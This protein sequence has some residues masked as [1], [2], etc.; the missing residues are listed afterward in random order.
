MGQWRSTCTTVEA[1]WGSLTNAPSSQWWKAE[2]GTAMKSITASS[3]QALWIRRV[4]RRMGA[5]V[6]ATITPMSQGS[7]IDLDLPNISMHYRT[8]PLLLSALLYLTASVSAQHVVPPSSLANDLCSCLGAIDPST[9]DHN[10]DLAVRQ[11]LNTTMAKHSSELIEL[12]RR[13]PAQ[14]RKLYLLGL[15]L[16]SALDRSCPQYPLV[17]DR[18]RLMLVLDTPT[19]PRT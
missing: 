1:P 19:A 15:V 5:K 7:T 16:G 9:N 14:D 3:S 17:K 11:C 2:R 4:D 12:L 18:L 8:I 10:F 6:S 13:Y